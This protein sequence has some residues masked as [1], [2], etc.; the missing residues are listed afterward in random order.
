MEGAKLDILN[1]IWH[2]GIIVK[3]V[4]GLLVAASVYSWA[5]ILKK[6]KLF[7]EVE[8][9]N[10]RFYEIYQNSENLKDIMIKS[11]ML[12]FSPYKALYTN[13][14]KEL[15]KMKEAY[16]GQ[17]QS[18]LAFHFQNFGMGVLERGLKKGANETNDELSKLLPTL[19][20]IGSVTPFVGLFGTVWGIIDAFAGLAGGGGSIDAVAPGIAE[21]LVAT[22]VG[23]AA[24]IP[25]VWFY[26]HFNSIN[27]KVN[28][29]MESFGQDFINVVE[30]SVIE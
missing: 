6:K 5:I 7:S 26:N 11:E 29:E 14:Y 3:I 20:S 10:K 13:G 18:G 12:P 24:A 19:A 9:N 28:S 8:E 17:H 27:E 15:V 23:L 30:R 2:S 21:A 1:I 16:S 22:A 4:L 25:A